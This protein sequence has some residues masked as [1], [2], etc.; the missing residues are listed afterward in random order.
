V[1]T[2]G[3]VWSDEFDEWCDPDPGP[4]S[5]DKCPSGTSPNNTAFRA[6]YPADVACGE[7][8]ELKQDEVWDAAG[9][10][11]EVEQ[12]NGVPLVRHQHD[13]VSEI[14]ALPDNTSNKTAVNGEGEILDQLD[15]LYVDPATIATVL[16]GRHMIYTKGGSAGNNVFYVEW[17]AGDDQAPVNFN[18]F[19][20]FTQYEGYPGDPVDP[21]EKG[22]WR[23]PILITTDG[24]VHASFAL[25]LFALID[26]Y[27]CDL[28]AGHYCTEYTPV[29]FD[30]LDW[31]I[32][33][34]LPNFPAAGWSQFE[35]YIGTDYIEIRFKPGGGA[36]AKTRIE[37]KYEGPFNKVAMGT[38]Q[39]V[40][41]SGVARCERAQWDNSEACVGGPNNGDAC[42]SGSATP[43]ADQCPPSIGTCVSDE[44][45]GGTN[46][47]NACSDDDDCPDLIECLWIPRGA[48][49]GQT[50]VGVWAEE[51]Y[52]EDGFYQS[53]PEAVGACCLGNGT[54]LDDKTESEC[55]TLDGIFTADEVTCA[56]TNCNGACCRTVFQGEC[57]DTSRDACNTVGGLFQGINTACTTADCPLL[58]N[59]PFADWD[60][61]GDV[62]QKDFG[63]FQV[64][65][66]GA[67]NAHADGCD[68]FNREGSDDD[69]DENDFAAF[70][71]CYSG[72]TV[73]AN[74]SCD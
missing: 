17:T 66:S 50:V 51:L 48:E 49:S 32:L 71:A 74:A 56:E 24:T 19:N 14:V 28:E 20:C 52:L 21:E 57:Q 6:Y 13:M 9:Y 40:E 69:I 22:K 34:E 46:H 26:D 29:A 7:Q 23:S 58:C 5:S 47:G 41:Q 64:C 60:E 37:R 30:G 25:G 62:D 1:A 27:N 42:D 39:G 67:G 4:G 31:V 73:P 44:C 70:S 68:C 10:A 36:W 65:Y 12:N 16:K 43:V 35:Y 15:P 61:D 55:D 18:M 3:V 8:Y 54:C 53:P 11:V 33:E 59:D 38:P 72:P 2:A 63:V 45:L